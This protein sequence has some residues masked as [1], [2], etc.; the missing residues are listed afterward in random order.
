MR[1]QN[2]GR[3][4]PEMGR[5]TRSGRS[6]PTAR[7]A[8]RAV[9][10]Q[11]GCGRC[12]TITA[13]SDSGGSREADG[14]D[15]SVLLGL[16]LDTGHYMFGGG[17][18]LEPLR[19]WPERIW[20]I[21]FKDF[22]P[23]VAERAKAEGWD[24]F[25]AVQNGVFCELG[26]A[27]SIFRRCGSD[28]RSATR[29]DRRRAGR[30]AV[31]GLAEE[32]AAGGI[33]AQY[34]YLALRALSECEAAMTVNMGHRRGRIGKVHAENLV[35]RIPEAR[36][37]AVADVRRAAQS[38]AQSLNIRRRPPT[39]VSLAIGRGCV[40]VCSSTDTHSE[41]I[42]AA[43]NAGKHIFAEKPIDLDLAVIDRVLA[44][45]EKAGVKFFVGFNRRFDPTYARVREAIQ[46]GELGDVHLIHVISRDPAPPPIEYVK[47]SGGIFMDMMIHDFDM[48]RFLVG[49]EVEEVYTRAAVRIDPRIGEAGDVDTAV[50]MLTF[51]N[52]AIG[53]ID[54]S[55]QAVYGYD[56]RVEVLGSKGAAS[57]GNVFPNQ[58]T[59]STA[60]NICRDLPLNFFMDRY[61]ESYE[62]EMR[63]FIKSIVDDTPTR[64]A[65]RRAHPGRDGAG[66]E[67][68]AA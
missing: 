55:R 61:T 65:S 47:V 53:T 2:A 13:G 63:A 43:A 28:G 7:T 59:F 50:V 37:L 38:L 1:T 67:E 60:T 23:D 17:D 6:S 39:T 52:G 62:R 33:S 48:I 41:I 36:V 34:W 44:A 58:V 68:V 49:S 16:V 20:H 19:L 35:Y 46:S 45:V 22:D 12:S 10:E 66:G 42:E 31:D 56:Q 32:S 24:Y 8:S 54:N 14:A 9:K 64:S 57:S 5:P 3:I 40:L 26:R 4:T 30:P 51:A 18:P 11:P 27:R 25:G 21:H 15:R 29:L